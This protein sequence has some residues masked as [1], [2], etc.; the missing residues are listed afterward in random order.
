MLSVTVPP[1]TAPGTHRRRDHPPD[2]SPQGRRAEDPSQYRHRGWLSR[3][4][5][6]K[7]SPIRSTDAEAAAGG[8][9]AR[10]LHR[11][12]RDWPYRRPG[13]NAKLPLAEGYPLGERW[14]VRG[15]ASPGSH[16]HAGFRPGAGGADCSRRRSEPGKEDDDASFLQGVAGRHAGRGGPLLRRLLHISVHEFRSRGVAPAFRPPRPAPRRRSP[17]VAR[18]HEGDEAAGRLAE[19]GGCRWSSRARRSATSSRAAAP[20]AS[21]AA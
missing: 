1:G 8:S 15:R 6:G 5:S 21:S 10:S 7:R 14:R 4:T 3:T 17:P 13:A 18:R 16:G 19:A 2:E 9:E 12:P 11:H 20:R